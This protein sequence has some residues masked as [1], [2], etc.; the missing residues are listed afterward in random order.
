MDAL[1]P[2][3]A[4]LPRF[5]AT[6]A[7]GRFHFLDKAIPDFTGS[8]LAIQWELRGSFHNESVERAMQKIVDRHEILRTRLIEQDGEI[9]QEVVPSVDFHMAMIDVRRLPEHEREARITRIIREVSTAPFDLSAPCPLRLTLVRFAPERAMLLIAVHHAVFD[10]FSIRVLGREIGA[11]IAAEETGVPADLPQLQ[12]QY[13]DY[14]QWQAACADSPARAQSAA[15]WEDTLGGAPYFELDSDTPRAPLGIRNGMR[16]DTDLGPEF[17]DQIAT[18]ARTRGLSAF[19]FGAGVFAAALHRETGAHD[20]SFGT[21]VAGREA[22]ELEDLIGVFVNP[23][24][25]R[26]KLDA[27]QTVSDVAAQSGEIV[28]EAL[29]H[30]DHPFDDVARH[31]HTR[32]DP[33]RTPLASV[34]FGLGQVFLEEHDYGPVSLASVPSATPGITH[35]LNVQIMGRKSG[36]KMMIDYDADRFSPARIEALSALILQTFDDAFAGSG[37]PLSRTVA[38]VDAPAPAR[39]IFADPPAAK[40][41]Q[42]ETAEIIAPLWAEIL[43]LPEDACDADF[44]DLGGHSLLAL[45]MLAR[46]ETLCGARPSI[47]DFLAA[48]SLRGLAATVDAMLGGPKA[49]TVDSPWRMIELAKGAANVPLLVTVNQPFLFHSVARKLNA[50]T[51]ALHLESLSALERPGALD[52]LAAHA[53][54]MIAEAAGARPVLMMGHC[55]DGV[56][57]RAIADKMDGAAPVLLMVDSWAPGTFDDTSTLARKT[58]RWITRANRWQQLFAQKYRG[59][60]SW[61]EFWA[62]NSF[63]ARRLIAKG[64]IDPVTDEEVR[65]VKINHRLVDLMKPKRFAPYAGEAILFQTGGQRRDARARLFGWKGLLGADTP[66]H[67]LPGWHEDAFHREGADVLAGIVN[68]RLA[69]F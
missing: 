47:T 58:R 17:A 18:A 1:A 64:R 63:L 37:A 33:L 29:A 48:P 68:A 62:K 20:I 25:L 50:R 67:D 55:V 56:F 21:A 40:S 11:L 34:F 3:H 43:G 53:A 8:N 26:Y 27:A 65:E 6:A 19:A 22:P 16:L 41:A 46:L 52:T 69:R 24:I 39:S 60:L 9:V 23:V 42:S 10:G 59:Q 7:Q 12:L 45:R 49:Q 5:P 4:N 51:V 57:A 66:V 61:D 32:P 35:D 44:F 13:G 14:A 30:A 54:T 38:A 2:S 15:F 31:L 28:R 36:W